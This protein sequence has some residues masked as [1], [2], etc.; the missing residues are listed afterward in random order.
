VVELTLVE[1]AARICRA[2]KAVLGHLSDGLYRTAASIGF[3]RE[4]EDYRALN[5]ITLDRGTTIGRMPLERRV[6]H[7]IAHV[8]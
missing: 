8:L 6:V 4:Y 7:C 5:P 3:T 1:T 2:D